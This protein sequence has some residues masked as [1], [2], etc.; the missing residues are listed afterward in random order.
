MV[1]KLTTVSK[2]FSP[3]NLY[4]AK[5]ENDALFHIERNKNA[6]IVQYDARIG[7]PWQR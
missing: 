3:T 5:L 2:P 1:P 7:L 4:G 6:N